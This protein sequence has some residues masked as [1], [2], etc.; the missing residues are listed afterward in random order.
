MKTNTSFTGRLLLIT[1]AILGSAFLAKSANAG[2]LPLEP[3]APAE[4]NFTGFYIGANIGGTWSDVDFSDYESEVDLLGQFFLLREPD[5]TPDGGFFNQNSTTF[6]SEGH[7]IG[8]A[9]DDSFMGGVQAGF[10]KQFG[11]FVVGVEGDFNRTA[12]K[13]SNNFEDTVT[14]L[15][16]CINCDGG[17]PSPD[18]IFQSE[19]FSTTDFESV[20]QAEMNWNASARLRVGYAKGPLM[21]Y[22]TG[23][24]AF[25]QLKVSAQDTARTNFFV[26]SSTFFEP[27]PNT[28]SGIPIT[29]TEDLGT[30]SNTHA[31]SDTDVLVGWTGG[32]G[33]EYALTDM[34]TIGLEYRHSDYGSETFSFGS[35]SPSFIPTGSSPDGMVSSSDQIVFPGHIHADLQNDQITFRVNVL[36]NR[37][38]GR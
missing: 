2:A 20:R 9:S 19:L 29:V 11:H 21:L 33:V 32:G 7:N 31:D 35:G 34:I 25:A 36:L 26:N 38:F 4:F 3:V 28:P 27:G 10:Q 13:S 14:F 17:D 15:Q 24:V 16:D 12:T 37:F 22:A 30:I 23:G 1:I 5:R 8:P 18:G 6:F